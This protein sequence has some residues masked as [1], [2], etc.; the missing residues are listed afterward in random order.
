MEPI[1]AKAGTGGSGHKPVLKKERKKKEKK[2]VLQL[3]MEL[4]PDGKYAGLSKLILE[5]HELR[6]NW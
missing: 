6:E 2:S 3:S 1:V 4:I 5:P